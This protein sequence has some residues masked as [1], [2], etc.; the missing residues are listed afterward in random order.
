MLIL[1][2]RYEYWFC[3]LGLHRIGAIAIPGDAPPDEEGHRLP[4]QR[5][6]REGHRVRR[7]RRRCWTTSTPPPAESPTLR[8]RIALGAQQEGLAG[9]RARDGQGATARLSSASRR[10]TRI[11]ASCTSPP[12]PPACPRWSSTISPIPSAT[13]SPPSTGRTCRTA[14]CTS[15][16]PTPAGPRR[17]GARSTASGSAGSAVFVYDYDRFVPSALLECH[18]EAQG[19]HLLRAADDVPLLHQGGPAGSTTSPR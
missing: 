16:W 5:G 12:A 18:R 9:P 10:R 13:S 1:K 14:A 6:G 3:L 11:P 19:H 8:H 2:R 7:T 15:P 17:R 4:Q